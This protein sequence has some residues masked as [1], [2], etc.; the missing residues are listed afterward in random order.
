MVIHVKCQFRSPFL[1]VAGDFNQ[2]DVARALEDFIDLT[3]VCAGPTR[4]SRTID[5][6]F[7]NFRDNVSAASTIPLLAADDPS[8]GR[9]SDHKVVI[10]SA[11]LPRVDLF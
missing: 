8:Q 11:D 4:G 9:P 2:W 10:V 5:R 3:E 6:V 7:V 1:V